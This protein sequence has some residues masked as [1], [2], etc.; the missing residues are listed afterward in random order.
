[1]GAGNDTFIWNPGDGNYI[2]E[3]DAGF[4]TLDFN[5]A[6]VAENIDISANG[7]RAKFFRD[8]ASVTMDLNDVE[9][10]DFAAL[11]GT[12]TIQSVILRG[13]T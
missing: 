12:D 10:V 9:R 8:V 4:D 1:M 13:P 5:G 7:T 3:G 2:V 11:G 6:G